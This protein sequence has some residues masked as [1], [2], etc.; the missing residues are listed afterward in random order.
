MA[1]LTRWLTHRPRVAVLLGCA[2]VFGAAALLSWWLGH[3]GEAMSDAPGPTVPPSPYRNTRPGVATVGDAACADCHAD[4]AE[5]YRR[6]PMGR[7]LR[8]TADPDGP[9]RYDAS[10]QN[11]FEKLG[12]TFAVERRDGRVT[13]HVSWPG[14]VGQPSMDHTSRVAFAI[15]SGARGRSYVVNLDGHLFQSPVSWFSESGRWGLSPGF[16]RAHLGGLPV[17][18]G[19]LFCHSNGANPVE[20]TVNRYH[21]PAE[22]AAVGC[23]RC[24]GPGELHV[25]RHLAAEPVGA[26]DDTIVNPAKLEPA[27]REAVCQQCHFTSTYR[28]VRRGHGTFD[29]RP[30]LPLQEFWTLFTRPAHLAQNRRFDNRVEQMTASRCF[31]ASGGK[32]GCTTCHDP[33]ATPAQE[34]APAFYR[35]RCLTCHQEASCAVPP[36]ERRRQNPADSCSACHMPRQGG[37]KAV[38]VSDTDHRIPR[39][40]GPPVPRAATVV[41]PGEALLLPFLRGLPGPD[42]AEVGRDLGLALAKVAA[43]TPPLRGHAARE[44]VPLLREA[45]RRWPDDVA[46]WQA[47]AAILRLVGRPELALADLGDA[48]ATTPDRES[49]LADAAA[50][51]AEVGDYEAARD[52]ARRAV[53]VNPQSAAHRARLAGALAAGRAW[54]AAVDECR[55]ALRIDPTCTDAR[56]VLVSCLLATGDKTAAQVEFDVLLAARPPNPEELRKWFA[57]RAR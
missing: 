24:H 17:E 44:A 43:D 52:Y 36:A 16:G 18:P 47:K 37:L 5:T 39:R 31:T 6:H 56:V 10:A 22:T 14:P 51:A 50:A 9:E 40:P 3:S 25:A 30:G 11:P 54:A 53:A 48:L 55:A 49:V 42:E 12:F 21:R 29:F 2:V 32:L 28:V 45:V 20:G 46:A 19:C 4:I 26:F 1:D 13:H 27:L 23:E 15:G 8:P 34:Q 38:H 7:D 35:G 33:H 41:R 57:E